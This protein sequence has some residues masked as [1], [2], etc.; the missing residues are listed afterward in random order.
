MQRGS[1]T[2]IYVTPA[3][4][5]LSSRLSTSWT[6]QT[7]QTSIMENRHIHTWWVKDW[8]ARDWR[9]AWTQLMKDVPLIIEKSG[10]ALTGP[11]GDPAIP[12]RKVAPELADVI[13][14]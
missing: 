13:K 2:S 11:S 6:T 9:K 12:Q 10:V 4:R 14:A 3:P 5:I 1:D 7:D 8:N